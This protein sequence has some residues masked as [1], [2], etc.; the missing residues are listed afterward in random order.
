ME[1]ARCYY[2]FDF[3]PSF[4]DALLAHARQGN[5]GSIDKVLAELLRGKDRLARWA[6]SK[7]VQRVRF[8]QEKAS[9]GGVRA[10]CPVCLSA[11]PLHR[12]R[13][14]T[15]R[16][17]PQR[18]CMVGRVRASLRRHDRYSG[19]LRASVEKSGENPR[20][21]PTFQHPMGRHVHHDA[22]AGHPTS[23]RQQRQL[24]LLAKLQEPRDCSSQPR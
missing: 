16:R 24:V 17:C 6:S 4:W 23:V 19:N 7:F 18:G 1:A 14:A 22:R 12:Q 3:A 15:F 10:C 13:Q 20:C 5:V 9:P 11:G 8:Y 21:L 2:H